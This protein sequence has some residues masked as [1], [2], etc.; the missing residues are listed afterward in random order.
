MP[1]TKFTNRPVDWHRTLTQ[2]PGAWDHSL[3]DLCLNFLGVIFF[4]KLGLGSVICW[5]T[6]NTCKYRFLRWLLLDAHMLCSWTYAHFFINLCMHAESPHQKCCRTAALGQQPNALQQEHGQ[7]FVNLLP[8]TRESHLKS[9]GIPD[10]SFEFPVIAT[11]WYGS[12][13]MGSLSDE[14]SWENLWTTMEN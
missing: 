13:L 10:F 12:Y 6:V 7:R 3:W 2:S 14:P 9:L 5:A 4:L 8:W 11:S 1:I